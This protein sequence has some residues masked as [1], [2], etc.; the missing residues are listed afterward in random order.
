MEHATMTNNVKY[1]LLTVFY[2]I[3]YNFFL[4]LLICIFTYRTIFLNRLNY[5]L[6]TFLLFLCLLII[7]QLIYRYCDN[8]RVRLLYRFLI[9]LSFASLIMALCIQTLRFVYVFVPTLTE[10]SIPKILVRIGIL[11]VTFY[12]FALVFAFI[13]HLYVHD[14]L[15][16]IWN[17][18]IERLLGRNS[19]TANHHDKWRQERFSSLL[20]INIL[21]WGGLASASTL[22]IGFIAWLLR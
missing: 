4:L 15:S 12:S 5:A 1:G 11:T 19:S 14:M 7:C 9:L 8:P 2:F 20:F 18:S 17:G 3:K 21:F 16:V 22:A 6:L 10:P 13:Y